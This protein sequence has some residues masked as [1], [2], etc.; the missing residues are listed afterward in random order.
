MKLT[1]HLVN[2]IHVNEKKGWHW[3]GSVFGI[4][5]YHCWT[6]TFTT[7]HEVFLFALVLQHLCILS[8]LLENLGLVGWTESGKEN[9]EAWEEKEVKLGCNHKSEVRKVSAMPDALESHWMCSLA[10]GQ[11]KEMQL[12][13]TLALDLLF[14]ATPRIANFSSLPMWYNSAP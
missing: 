11:N 14:S 7:M 1:Q 2:F 5:W 12:P 6:H 8:S 13:R 10:R 4:Q 9:L 3:N